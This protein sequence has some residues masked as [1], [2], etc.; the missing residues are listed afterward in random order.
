LISKKIF[1]FFS[2]ALFL[3]LFLLIPIFQINEG[4]N[5]I[6]LNQDKTLNDVENYRKPCASSRQNSEIIDDVFSQKLADYSSSGYFPQ[7]YESSLQGTYYALYILNATG[8]LNQV[9][10]SK[11]LSYILSQYNDT[12]K[13]FIDLS[14]ERY[15][16]TSTDRNNYPLTSWLE[17]NCYAVL[18]L[19]ILNNLSTIDTQG[20]IDFIWSC[21]N[22]ESSGFVGQPYNSLL[23]DYFITSTMDNTYYA[24]T[25]LDVLNNWGAHSNERDDI[26]TYIGSLQ[27]TN[28]FEWYFGGFFNDNDSA[29][30]S[31]MVFEPNLMSSYYCLKS[32][33]FFGMIGSINVDNF[34]QYLV[35]LYND[36]SDFFNFTYYP[37]STIEVQANLIGSALGLELSELSGLS[38]VDR[39]DVIDF[40]LYH[41]NPNELWYEST[42]S[43]NNDMVYT[44]HI[45]HSLVELG[46]ISQ[47]N[48]TSKDQIGNKIQD[49]S[50]YDDGYSLLSVDYMSVELLYSTISSFELYDRINELDLTGLYNVIKSLFSYIQGPSDYG[51]FHACKLYVFDMKEIKCYPIE[52]F[53]YIFNNLN[54]FQYH[55]GVEEKYSHKTT[56]QALSSLKSL[57][58]LD[59]FEIEHNITKFINEIINTQFLEVGFDNF[60][61]FLPNTVDTG[62]TPEYQNSK[63]F[64]EY[65]FYAIKT[66]ELL[67]DYLGLGNL[68]DVEFDIDAL[69]AYINNYVEGGP[70]TLYFNPQYT[71][72]IE[73]ILENTYYMAYVLNSLNRYTYDDQ[74]IKNYVL[75]S[76]NYSN[77]KNVYYS[78]KI[79]KLLGLNIEFD[80]NL[81]HSLVQNIYSETHK[82]FYLTTDKNMI[83]QEVFLWISDM[84]KNDDVRINPQYPSTIL[85]GSTINITAELCNIM[86]E[87]FGPYI[88]VKLESDQIGTI[89]LNRLPDNRF[90]ENI[91]IPVDSDNYPTVW[92]N[93]SAYNGSIKK[94]ETT[95]NFQTSYNLSII[96]KI[97]L[98]SDS[99]EVQVNLSLISGLGSQP[100]FG[101]EIFA[102]IYK[103]TSYLSDVM[104]SSEDFLE[105]SIF[106]L[107]Y[108]PVSQGDYYFLVY[109]DDD[110]QNN[111]TYLFNITFNYENGENELGGSDSNSYLDYNDDMIISIPIILSF[112]V[113]PSCVMVISS[114]YKNQSRKDFKLT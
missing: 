108:S 82:E 35:G 13:N 47:L 20:M 36:N 28:P 103:D 33:D 38:S 2:L 15:L 89:T 96:P 72:N 78:Y 26:L 6:C 37:F 30:D 51:R 5:R 110:Y 99:I 76:L 63:I 41:R 10:Q 58:K 18:S 23:P 46:E 8:K 64:F 88:T 113:V 97:L 85:L 21:Y 27:S 4:V 55:K 81:T 95:I 94:A 22:P 48:Q 7:I 52:Y 100:L 32:L 11:I 67:V 49:F 3:S 90:Q 56:F 66:L 61:A 24:I 79:S 77:I 71:N 109:L 91:F 69:C 45:I 70:S 39:Q 59:D 57:F 114:K 42:E 1:K 65:T 106:Q 111:S 84:A 50:Q 60:G 93:L 17:S 62:G 107:D 16:A 102:E 86:L 9:N 31:L 29:F 75:Q 83:D 19:D 40:I 43:F 14:A 104:F 92:G 112:L 87:D 73:I 34:N 12:S 53:N 80:V 25:T 105:H 68:T 74:K 44:Y 101:S 54:N 98:N